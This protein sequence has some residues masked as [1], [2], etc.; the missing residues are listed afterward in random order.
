[1]VLPVC[2]FLCV[3][4][5]ELARGF[6][7]MRDVERFVSRIEQTPPADVKRQLEKFATDLADLNPLVRNASISA[8]KVATGKNLAPMAWDWL[9]WWR[10]N[11]ATWQYQPPRSRAAPTPAQQPVP[12]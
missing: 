5:M 11:E 7:A 4:V 6:L 12:P 9:A 2:V 8:M 1:M 10:E 3:F